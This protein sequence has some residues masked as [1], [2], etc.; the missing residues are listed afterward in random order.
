MI[1]AAVASA[2]LKARQRQWFGLAWNALLPC[3][4]F[5]LSL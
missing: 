1:P 3:A 2:V 4:I 5:G